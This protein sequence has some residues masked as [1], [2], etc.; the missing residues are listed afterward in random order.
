[1][2]LAE[3][4][5]RARKEAGLT[6]RELAE[7]VGIHTVTVQQYEYG[8]RLPKYEYL[9]ELAAA[10]KIPVSYFLDDDVHAFD[11][12]KQNCIERVTQMLSAGDL[13]CQLAEESA[14]LTKA[15]LKVKRALEG[16]NP[17][18]TRLNDA[19]SNLQEELEDVLVCVATLSP[20]FVTLTDAPLQKLKRW[21]SRL[22]TADPQKE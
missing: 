12:E 21:V 15:A 17:T 20:D 1:M 10:L 11:A 6:Q 13:L 3:K 22:E 18:P 4:L 2:M 9:H 5:K 19:L 8:K 16:K 7:M 14:E